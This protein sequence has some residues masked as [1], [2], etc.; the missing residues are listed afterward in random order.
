MNNPFIVLIRLTWRFAK[1]SRRTLVAAY[2]LLAVS[3]IIDMSR[4]VFFALLLNTVQK[5]G[6]HVIRD[7][8]LI[9]AGYYLIPFFFWL[10]HGTGRVLEQKVSYVVTKQYQESLFGSVT[11][12]PLVWH[13]NHHSGDTIDRIKK[14]TNAEY[15]FSGETWVAVS[16]IM[17]MIIAFGAIIWAAP[18]FGTVSLFMCA[19]IIA[20]IMAFD[21]RLTRL[22]G[23]INDHDHNT[24]STIHDY[25]TNIIT[26]ITLR[27]EAMARK[28]V[29]KR[30]ATRHDSYHT[31]I[32]LNEIKWF[33][34]SMMLSVMSYLILALF[35]VGYL[36]SGQAVLI[37]TITMLYQYVDRMNGAFFDFAW[38][39]EQ[40]VRRY[41]DTRA[42]D[43]IIADHQLL[44]TGTPS[45]TVEHWQHIEIRHLNFSHQTED[46]DREHLSDIHVDLV[47]GRKIALVGESGSGKSTLMVLLR[48]L[49][50]AD[51]VVVQVDGKTFD[52]LS[53]L[54]DL[55]TL[56]PQEPEIFDN[57]IEY[58]IVAGL[59]HQREDA[60][61]AAQI[62]CFDQVVARLPK[63]YES[64]M[65][66]RGVNLSGGEKQRLALARGIFAAHSS[67]LI[68]LDEPT[69]SVDAVNEARIY[70]NMFRHFAGRC[71]VSS[72]H[73]LHLLTMFDRIYVL[74]QGR[75]V[76][77]GTF[78]ELIAK[79][80]RLASMWES[81]QAAA[82]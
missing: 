13:K 48:G 34:V 12:M 69:S 54:R 64:H 42:V 4:P 78:Q 68:L 59:A 40:I 43:P 58:N 35:L 3:S 8:L 28:A 74:D 82:K 41:V 53:V 72:I 36:T 14:A 62:A 37:G 7:I 19:G 55:S 52:S 79:K 67:S 61:V 75:V 15:D 2:T 77:E 47:R 81:Y 6:D 44:V 39:Y 21:R 25:I 20:T 50:Q 16:I 80:S 24:A 70:Q 26:V 45:G 32:V 76:E 1:G 5:G 71:I 60:E 22:Q 57:T 23:E 56:I 66:E 9:L 27:I 10:F 29:S 49:L 65:S 38:Q 46:Q 31:F 73:K 30:I 51:Q 11:E 33:T 17:R 63:G 18:V